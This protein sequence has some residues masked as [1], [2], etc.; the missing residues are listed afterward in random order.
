MNIKKSLVLALLTIFLAGLL[1]TAGCG[2]NSNS[3]TTGGN[4]MVI[5]TSF[6]PIYIM[7][8][9]VAADVPGVKVINITNPG[10]GCLHDYQLSPEDL[11]KLQKASVL[12]INGAGME[13]FLDKVVEQQPKLKIVEASRGIDFITDKNGE[14]NPHVWVSVSLARQ[15]V[16]NIAEQLAEL[17]SAHADQYK[18][19]AK[20]YNQKLKDLRDQM[21]AGLAD[22]KNRD[23]I[24]F[25][26]AFPYFAKE[27]DLRVVAVIEREPGSE[28]SA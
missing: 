2:N 23:I 7:T 28:P 17:D 15:Q 25:H 24:T 12:V 27:L 14:K 18:K 9:N 8:M 26:E 1:T 13:S 3:T 19:N 10:T 6:Y 20:V 11:K 16:L 4:E 21:H 5:A 22:V